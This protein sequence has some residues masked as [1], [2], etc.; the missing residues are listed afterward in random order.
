M[1]PSAIT[2]QCSGLLT[3]GITPPKKEHTEEKIREICQAQRERIRA[4]PVD[5]LILYDIQDEKDRMDTQR[6]FPFLETVDPLVYSEN[7][8]RD[9]E[10]PRIIYRCVGKY[11]REE[12]EASLV[13]QPS[14]RQMTV[15]VGAASSK[16]SGLSL[17]E[18]YSIAAVHQEQLI[19][20]GVMIPERHAKKGDE[21]LR[22]AAKTSNGCRFFVSQAIY[23]IETAK[24][25]L[26]DYAL[27]CR[28]TGEAP[29]P[30]LFTLTPCGSEKT[31]TFMKWLGI[32]IPHWLEND[33]ITAPDILDASLDLS[34]SIFK[35]LWFYA[36]KKGIPVGCN[37]E[38]VS[39]RKV[40]IEASVELVSRVARIMGR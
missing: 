9:L 19:L 11:S 5:A 24:D 30:I 38:S 17:A 1:I 27:H 22:V 39:T 6:P 7:Y 12:L 8:L 40:E 33:L 23:N 20:G 14:K 2:Q 15:F 29:V 26:S 21:H 16:S 35:E 18:A 25:F 37:V 28:E 34:E 10:L 4:L 31:L 3:Y 32:A 13:P 36:H